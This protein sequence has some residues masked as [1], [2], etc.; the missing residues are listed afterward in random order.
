VRRPD[1]T[2][3]TF[4]INDEDVISNDF[5]AFTSLP[6]SCLKAGLRTLHLRNSLGKRDQDFEY[7]SLFVRISKEPLVEA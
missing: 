5:V 2:Y 3:L 7:A 1:L 4:H 6:V